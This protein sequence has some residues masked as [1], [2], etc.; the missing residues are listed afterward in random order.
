[1]STPAKPSRF[2]PELAP[3]GVEVRFYSQWRNRPLLHGSA[4]LA[5]VHT[6][7]AEEEGSVDSAS[8]TL[9]SEMRARLASRRPSSL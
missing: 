9:E 1:M 3:N 8:L 7:A 2:H 4:R 6:N 5:V